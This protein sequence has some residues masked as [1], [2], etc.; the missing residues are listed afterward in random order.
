MLGKE[1]TLS[2]LHGVVILALTFTPILAITAYQWELE[3]IYFMISVALFALLML[4]NVYRRADPVRFLKIFSL[5]KEFL[6]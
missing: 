4:L 2:K 1:N 6:D 5:V 3:G